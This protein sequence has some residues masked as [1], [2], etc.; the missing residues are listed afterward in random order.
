VSGLDEGAMARETCV[1]APSRA[2]GY[3][4][5]K[6][7]LSAFAQLC[8]FGD[9]SQSIEVHIGSTYHDNEFLSRTHEL[10]VQNIPFQACQGKGTC[11]FRD[12]TGLYIR[13]TRK[14]K[15]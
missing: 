7:G 15:G 3:V 13:R 11:G 5:T 12:R 6:Q 9:E 10:V 4:H 1:V 8:T 2:L 14:G